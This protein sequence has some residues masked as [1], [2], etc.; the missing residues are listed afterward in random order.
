MSRERRLLRVLLPCVALAVGLAARQAAASERRFTYT[1]ESATLA[2]GQREI[3]P[4][5]TFRMG[6]DGFYNRVDNRLELEFGLTDRLQTSWYLNL[7]GITEDDPSPG[8]GR[9]SSFE[10]A[11]VSWELK[12]KLMDP[13]ADPV[14]MAL[15]F[16]ATGGPSELELEGKLILDK[17][18]G[19]WL[20]AMNLVG[21]QEWELAGPETEAELLLEAVGAVGYFVTP[22][23]TLG[24]EVRDHN[25]I[26]HGDKDW[27]SSALFAGPAVS[28]AWPTWWTAVSVLP[29]LG[30]LKREPGTGSLDLADHERVNARLIFGTHF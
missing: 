30:N 12:Y 10:H 14:G 25:V 3:E 20:L 24:L 23:L 1:Y 29:Q 15:Y 22:H 28:Y 21:E 11:G 19:S 2:P 9:M 8:P 26:G 13:V 7:T 5:T 4:W 27:E 16:E 17:R 6:R 18:I